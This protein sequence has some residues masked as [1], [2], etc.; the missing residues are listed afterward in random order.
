MFANPLNTGVFV[1]GTRVATTHLGPILT[2]CLD[3]NLQRPTHPG[4]GLTTAVVLL[5]GIVSGAAMAAGNRQAPKAQGSVQVGQVPT[6]ATPTIPGIPGV[7]AP[8]THGP[9]TATRVAAPASVEMLK[10][11]A[12]VPAA[13]TQPAPVDD[14]LVLRPETPYE[15]KAPETPAAATQALNEVPAVTSTEPSLASGKPFAGLNLG[16]LGLFMFALLGGAGFLAYRKK[17]EDIQQDGDLTLEVASTIR[18]G[19]KWQ[20]SLV[21]VPGRILVVGATERGLELLTELYPEGDEE[22]MDDLLMT[23]NAAPTIPVQTPQPVLSKPS[24]LPEDPSADAFDPLADISP[25]Y[26]NETR[27]AGT[28]SRQPRRASTT[29]PATAQAAAP[30]T[31]AQK[32]A[33]AG[34]GHDDAFLDAVLD[35]LSK[36]RPAVVRHTTK[37]APRVDE[38]AALRAQVKQYRRGPTRL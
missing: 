8:M 15:R 7:S 1:S 2:R 18:I 28:Y 25:R 26:G 32:T 11:K 36:A 3:M 14:A 31:T 9:G 22:V 19:A 21:R 29:S 20:V 6:P 10:R 33:G 12:T 13:P 24:R 38:R 27:S 37:P 5:C 4:A 23:A 35:R 30:M 16:G 17:Q 34:Q